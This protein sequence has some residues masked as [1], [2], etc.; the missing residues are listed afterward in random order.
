MVLYSRAYQGLLGFELNHKNMSLDVGYRYFNGGQ[1][2]SNTY[3]TDPVSGYNYPTVAP[4]WKGTL[5]ANE[6]FLD[7][8]YAI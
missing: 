5:A 4:A 7:L 1:F 8:R 6:V 2:Q 3:L